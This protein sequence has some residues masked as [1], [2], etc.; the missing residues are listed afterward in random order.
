MMHD[1]PTIRKAAILNLKRLVCSLI[2]QELM[3]AENIKYSER[4]TATISPSDPLGR[5][6]YHLVIGHENHD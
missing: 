4:N 2:L 3:Q 1:T 5:D 6:L